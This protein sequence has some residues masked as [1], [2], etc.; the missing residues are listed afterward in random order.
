MVLHTHLL[1]QLPTRLYASVSK[2]HQRKDFTLLTFP[3]LHKVTSL[4]QYT[5][6]Y[7]QFTHNKQPSP[8]PFLRSP[9]QPQCHTLTIDAFHCGTACRKQC[10][11][12]TTFAQTQSL[13][14]A[15]AASYHHFFAGH[16]EANQNLVFLQ[17]LT[18][19]FCSIR[20][21]FH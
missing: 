21:C 15:A 5:L 8:P 19:L 13:H 10:V 14:K 2:E 17:I 1:V 20:I 16:C 7:L 3:L 11:K 18:F 4:S 12:V 6:H 9:A